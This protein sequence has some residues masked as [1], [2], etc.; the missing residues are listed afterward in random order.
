MSFFLTFFR[1]LWVYPVHVK[2][3]VYVNTF[4]NSF[5]LNFIL[6]LNIFNDNGG[7]YD[8]SNFQVVYDTHGIPTRLSCRHTSQKNEKS[9]CV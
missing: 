7:E 2:S 8:N 4:I 6:L 3:D 9:E 5:K 1:L